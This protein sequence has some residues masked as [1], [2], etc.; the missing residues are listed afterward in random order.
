LIVDGRPYVR[1]K[2]G[3]FLGDDIFLSLH[4]QRFEIGA[5]DKE[6]AYQYNRRAMPSQQ[7]TPNR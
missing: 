5:T 4:S 3:Q 2:Y 1:G 6:E 7:V